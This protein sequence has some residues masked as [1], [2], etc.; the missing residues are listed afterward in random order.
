MRMRMPG[1]YDIVSFEGLS[2]RSEDETGILRSRDYIHSLISTEVARG[3]PP[4]R[5]V[6]G[7]F[8][9]GAAISVLSGLTFASRLAGIFSLSGYLL[10]P[11]KVETMTETGVNKPTKIFWGH[12]TQD[13]LVR[14]SFGEMSVARLRE[15]GYGVDFR[16]YQCVDLY[17]FGR[18]GSWCLTCCRNLVHSVSP[19]EIDDL[20]AYLM[21]Q[22]PSK[23]NIAQP[24]VS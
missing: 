1:W 17:L 13:P 24:S 8:S 9:Q 5:I 18:V 19:E 3:T 2:G 11:D 22:L 14:Y 15:L 21:Q 16:S 10:L 20:E 7:G 4:D 23:P 6:V 12:G